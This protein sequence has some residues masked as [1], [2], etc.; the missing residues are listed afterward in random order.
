MVVYKGNANLCGPY[1]YSAELYQ[2]KTDD[3]L[4]KFKL[5]VQG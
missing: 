1:T 3:V 4:R 2:L 5:K